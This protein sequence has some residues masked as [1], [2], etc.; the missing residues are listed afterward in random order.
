MYTYKLYTLASL[1]LGSPDAAAMTSRV[2]LVC[3]L[4]MNKT[5]GLKRSAVTVPSNPLSEIV[6]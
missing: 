1:K 4:F 5:F 3:I 6:L 2:V